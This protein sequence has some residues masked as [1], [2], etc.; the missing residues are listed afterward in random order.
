MSPAVI[1]LAAAG[2]GGLVLMVKIAGALSRGTGRYFTGR[3][4]QSREQIMT[5]IGYGAGLLAVV[6]LIFR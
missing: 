1:L 3:Y 4:D 5:T 6:W 2:V